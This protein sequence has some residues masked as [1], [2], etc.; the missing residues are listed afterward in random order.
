MM[1]DNNKRATLVQLE[2]VVGY[3]NEVIA[4]VELNRS[5]DSCIDVILQLQAAQSVLGDECAM[6]LCEQF[7]AS[8]ILAVQ[9]AVPLER[10]QALS[11]I[12]ELF[13]VGR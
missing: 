3:I 11:E 5:C 2:S 1:N 6:I 9:G 7:R 13:C 8:R 10:E 4:L 12:S